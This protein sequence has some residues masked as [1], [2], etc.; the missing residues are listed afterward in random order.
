MSKSEIARV[1]NDLAAIARPV[2]PAFRWRPCLSDP[3]DDMVLE[4]ALNG[5]ARAIV[6]FN[7]RD[8]VAAGNF[9]CSVILPKTALEQIRS[10]IDEK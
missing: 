5:N 7:Q 9:N 3:G 2:R 10:A 8:F 6:T 1:L 4:T